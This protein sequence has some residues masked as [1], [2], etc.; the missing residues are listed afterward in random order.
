MT[1]FASAVG[2]MGVAIGLLMGPTPAALASEPA[3]TAEQRLAALVLAGVSGQEMPALAP[4]AS[5]LLWV[6]SHS[7][8]L[9][10]NGLEQAQA[11]TRRLAS[12]VDIR[13]FTVHSVDCG[14]DLCWIRYSYGFVARVGN[15]DIT[16]RSDNQEVWVREGERFVFAYGVGRQ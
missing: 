13:N 8:L 16:G 10:R 7:K 3:P 14:A 9:D 6:G 5:Y 1:R 12:S 11:A 4:G 15:S 2:A